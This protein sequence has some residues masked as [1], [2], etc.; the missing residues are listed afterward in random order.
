MEQNGQSASEGT[1]TAPALTSAAA[2]TSPESPAP[3][4]A[5]PSPPADVKPIDIHDTSPAPQGG[6]PAN[7]QGAKLNNPAE[8]RHTNNMYSAVS[9]TLTLC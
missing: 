1:S 3:I 4:A 9:L 8:S 7:Q 2:Q 6:H 5:S